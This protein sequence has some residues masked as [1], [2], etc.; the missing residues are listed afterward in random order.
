[1][2]DQRASLAPSPGMQAVPDR[3]SNWYD[4]DSAYDY[5]RYWVGREY[6]HGAEQLAI[7]RLLRGVHIGDALDVGGG[8]GR[9]SQLLSAYADRV[10][11]VEPSEH[12]LDLAGQ[13]LHGTGVALHRAD[14]TNLRLPTASADLIVLARVMHHIPEPEP[15]FTEF[16]RV[17]RPGGTL[18][19]EFANS[20]HF[21]NRARWAMKR[22]S[23]PEHPIHLP[24]RQQDNWEIPF[25]NHHPKRIL[26][27]LRAA[28]FDCQA[29]LSVSNLRSATLKRIL[30]TRTLLTIERQLQSRLAPIWFGPSIWLRLHRIPTS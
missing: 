24:H 3:R 12:Q 29:R 25:V 7:R 27:Q 16:A 26:T 14:A 2:L 30:P 23:V 19:L 22:R 18:L 6:E 28:G 4:D 17:L 10:T 5:R 20:A 8:F 1:M 9:H 13:F 11:L 21:V 15:V